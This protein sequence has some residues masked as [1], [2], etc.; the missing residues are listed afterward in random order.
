MVVSTIATIK[1]IE[2]NVSNQVV[3]TRNTDDGQVY[4]LGLEGVRGPDGVAKDGQQ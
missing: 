1:A 2:E 3:L 4:V